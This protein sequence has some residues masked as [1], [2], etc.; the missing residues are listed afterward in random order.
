M[1]KVNLLKFNLKYSLSLK[2]LNFKVRNLEI[3]LNKI[4]IIKSVGANLGLKYFI[5]AKENVFFIICKQHFV[6]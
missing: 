5:E 2:I 3:V 6:A 4:E 1:S